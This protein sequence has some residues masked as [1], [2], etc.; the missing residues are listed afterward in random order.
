[1]INI[2]TANFICMFVEPMG[3]P[4]YNDITLGLVY[5]NGNSNVVIKGTCARFVQGKEY[6]ITVSEL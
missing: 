5:G 6:L 2:Y 1:M 4:G 3:V